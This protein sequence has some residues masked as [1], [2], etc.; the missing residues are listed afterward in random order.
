MTDTTT[1]LQATTDPEITNLDT[2]ELATISDLH[3]IWA[4]ADNQRARDLATRS[5]NRLGIDTV[6]TAAEAHLHYADL[7]RQALEEAAAR[8]N[9]KLQ[10]TPPSIY[11]HHDTREMITEQL[12]D[13]LGLPPHADLDDY[14]D[15]DQVEQAHATA[16]TT[17]PAEYPEAPRARAREDRL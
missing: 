16:L 14:I 4:T 11:G 17:G 2:T 8:T 6:K 5:L 12:Y 15:P 13:L 10:Y 7:T 9:D 3:L 1:T